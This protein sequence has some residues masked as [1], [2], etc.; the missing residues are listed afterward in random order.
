MLDTRPNNGL[1]AGKTL[2]VNVA[3]AT[4]GKTVIGQLTVDQV[5]GPGFVTAYACSAGLPKDSY[6]NI[7]KSDL[8]YNGAV[9]PVWSNRLVVN[10]DNTRAVL[11]PLREA[12]TN[13]TTTPTSIRFVSP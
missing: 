1:G 5:N 4:G 10:A 13:G 8:N 2:T 6:G 7:T 3:S 9:T 12:D 11:V